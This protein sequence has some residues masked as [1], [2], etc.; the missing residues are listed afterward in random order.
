MCF[1]DHNLFGLVLQ[2]LGEEGTMYKVFCFSQ[3]KLNKIL[4]FIDIILDYRIRKGFC[5]ALIS[6]SLE[7]LQVLLTRK[8]KNNLV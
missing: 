1:V 7:L 4:R 5:W 3:C 2:L 8:M 6:L